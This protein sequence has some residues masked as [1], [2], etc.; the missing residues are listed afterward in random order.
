MDDM[1]WKNM[2]EY[3]HFWKDT[4]KWKERILIKN[5]SEILFINKLLRQRG[6]YKSL[7]ICYGRRKGLIIIN[8]II[9]IK[10]KL[11]KLLL[12]FLLFFC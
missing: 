4:L 2:E 10:L 6:P 3:S 1:I 9:R 7:S 11:I 8:I 12:S 5:E